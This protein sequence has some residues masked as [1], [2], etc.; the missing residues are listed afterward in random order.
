[1][2]FVALI[3]AVMPL[4]VLVAEGSAAPIT[5]YSFRH[6]AR[7]D[8]LFL[9]LVIRIMGLG[10]LRTHRSVAVST[11]TPRKRLALSALTPG[12]TTAPRH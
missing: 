11:R 8:T 7:S 3:I 9:L 1:M 5:I 10:A 2:F 12:S 6:A 4:E